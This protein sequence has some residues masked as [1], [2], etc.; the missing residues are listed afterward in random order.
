MKE[1][2]LLPGT[3]KLAPQA[4]HGGGERHNTVAAW[5]HLREGVDEVPDVPVQLQA[6]QLVEALHA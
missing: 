4:L 5:A 1:A 6:A 2:T 3:S